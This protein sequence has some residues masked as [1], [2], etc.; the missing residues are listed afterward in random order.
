MNK[1]T[2][3]SYVD[4]QQMTSQFDSSVMNTDMNLIVEQERIKDLKQAAEIQDKLDRYYVLPMVRKA[5]M[6]RTAEHVL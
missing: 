3:D 2:L 1:T 4:Q 6:L 5:V